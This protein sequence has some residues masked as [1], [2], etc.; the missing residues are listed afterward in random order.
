MFSAMFQLRH[1]T[2]SLDLMAC[3]NKSRSSKLTAAPSSTSTGHVGETWTRPGK[4]IGDE[5]HVHLGS[6]A[7]KIV[8]S[9]YDL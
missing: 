5:N 4:V 2:V 3:I 8:C 7:F 1:A 9:L 6:A